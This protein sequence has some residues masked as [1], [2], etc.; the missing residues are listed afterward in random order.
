MSDGAARKL[1]SDNVS[2]T[3]KPI[4]SRSSTPASAALDDGA[5]Q[6]AVDAPA[7][8]PPSEDFRDDEADYGK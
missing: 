4:A 3:L 5:E 1:S 8:G 2:A 6:A 7:E